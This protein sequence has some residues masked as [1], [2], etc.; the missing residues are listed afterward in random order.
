VLFLDY[1][2]WLEHSNTFSYCRYPFLLTVRLPLGNLLL[3]S[4]LLSLLS[5]HLIRLLARH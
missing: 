1:I 4:P 5:S 2:N 3:S